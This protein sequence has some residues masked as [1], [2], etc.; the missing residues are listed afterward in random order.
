[1]YQ[2]K[3]IFQ[4]MYIVVTAIFF[5]LC[6]PV[7]TK[8]ETIEKEVYFYDGVVSTSYA[9]DDGGGGV[10]YKYTRIHNTDNFDISGLKAV[11]VEYYPGYAEGY[12]ITRGGCSISVYDDEENLLWNQSL[13]TP[14]VYM[15]FLY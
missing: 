1:M 9:G 11:Y 4:T 2:Y 10:V 12:Y 15:V 3:K 6:L 5:S 8:A 7:V 14:S 13:S